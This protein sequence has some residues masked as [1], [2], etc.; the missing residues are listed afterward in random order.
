MGRGFPIIS[1]TLDDDD[2]DAE[3]GSLTALHA[4]WMTWLVLLPLPVK[5]PLAPVLGRSARITCG[6]VGG[7]VVW[8]VGRRDEI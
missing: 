1:R 4:R 7:C 2:D 8:G 6:C 3:A 5:L